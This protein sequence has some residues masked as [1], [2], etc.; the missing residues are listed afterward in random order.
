MSL[1]QDKKV[2]SQL[3]FI[4]QVLTQRQ[5]YFIEEFEIARDAALTITSMANQLADKIKAEEEALT[6]KDVEATDAKEVVSE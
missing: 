1:D 2:H 3:A 4:H 6:L 5:Q